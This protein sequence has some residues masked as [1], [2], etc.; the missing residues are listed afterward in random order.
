MNSCSETITTSAESTPNIETITKKFYHIKGL[1]A[2]GA[3]YSVISK[4]G[5][6]SDNRSN[7]EI[8]H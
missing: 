3:E 8:R 5:E 4:G 6:K 7:R 1:I 2:K